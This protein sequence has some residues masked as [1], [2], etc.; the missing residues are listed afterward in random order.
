M[1][2]L[3]TSSHSGAGPGWSRV[4]VLKSGG[5]Y[6]DCANQAFVPVGDQVIADH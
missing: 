3:R 1:S 2:A 6:S 4:S 5:K